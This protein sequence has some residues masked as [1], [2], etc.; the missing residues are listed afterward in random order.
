MLHRD[1]L[2]NHHLYMNKYKPTGK[3]FYS[4]NL[5]RKPYQISHYLTILRKS[6]KRC[7]YLYS[8]SLNSLMPPSQFRCCLINFSNASAY[9][10]KLLTDVLFLNS[11]FIINKCHTLKNSSKHISHIRVC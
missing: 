4:Q 5:I 6:F 1:F 3:C 7:S 2:I 8:Y 11:S 9:S 10:N